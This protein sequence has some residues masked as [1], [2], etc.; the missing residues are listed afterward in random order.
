MRRQQP[1]RAG[2]ASACLTIAPHDI[3]A[4]TSV[5]PRQRCP[6]GRAAGQPGHTRRPHAG[7][8]AALPGRV[9]VGSAGGGDTARAVVADPER[10]DPAHPARKIGRE[11][12]IDLDRAGFAAAVVVG[13]AG[14]AAAGRAGR[15]W[16]RRAGAPR[17][18][19]RR[20]V[21]GQCAG[22]PAG[23]GRHPGAGAAAVPPVRCGHHRQH[24]RRSGG[25]GPAI[26]PHAPS[27][28]SSTATTT[29]PA[30]SPPWPPACASTGHCRAA[31]RS[32]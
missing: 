18:A 13:P 19:L 22:R 16:P 24:L 14:R 9:P 15:T 31:A 2:P 26:A 23:R 29:T 21:G 6:H 12:R 25:L 30:T 4:R 17:H 7:S 10:C 1:W 5:P 28:A 3:C 32:W 11:V 27:C 8:L 20:A